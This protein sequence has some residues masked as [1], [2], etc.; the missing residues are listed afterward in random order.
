MKSK[1][2]NRYVFSLFLFA[3]FCGLTGTAYAQ[4]GTFSNVNFEGIITAETGPS[5]CLQ[6]TFAVRDCTGNVLV[7]IEETGNSVN[8]NNFL[9]QFVRV[10]GED[11][12]VECPVIRV[13]RFRPIANRCIVPQQ[14]FSRR[15]GIVTRTAEGG[16][17]LRDCAGN[18]LFELETSRKVGNLEPFVGSF[19]R[20]RGIVPAAQQTDLIRNLRVREVTIKPNQCPTVQPVVV[21]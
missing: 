15:E 13:T 20:L 17:V 3:C 10:R 12:G 16:F 19:V 8:P 6:G 9:G 5:I 4:N 1:V 18:T 11:V 21:R 14:S 7:R 2:F